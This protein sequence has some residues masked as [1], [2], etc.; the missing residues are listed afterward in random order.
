L[1]ALIVTNFATLVKDLGRVINLVAIGRNILTVGNAAQKLAGQKHVDES[2]L[3]LITICIKIAMRGG[4]GGSGINTKDDDKKIQMVVNDCK[5][6]EAIHFA[7]MLIRPL[8]SQETPYYLPPIP[9]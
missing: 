3:K 7:L 4:G 8:L 1:T 5:K 6:G 2:V 9:E